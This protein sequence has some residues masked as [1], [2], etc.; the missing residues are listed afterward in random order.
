MTE[1]DATIAIT[2]A[3]AAARKLSAM[4]APPITPAIWNKVQIRFTVSKLKNVESVKRSLPDIC[5]Q[6][7]SGHCFN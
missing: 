6:G 5:F 3:I 1:V 4:A 7:R 2:L